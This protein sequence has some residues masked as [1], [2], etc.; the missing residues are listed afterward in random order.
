[1][2]CP[3]VRSKKTRTDFVQKKISEKISFTVM[4]DCEKVHEQG[5]LPAVSLHLPRS[6]LKKYFM[7]GDFI[8]QSFHA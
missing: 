6:E 8:F 4:Y 5:N 3:S 1:M 2:C 7:M